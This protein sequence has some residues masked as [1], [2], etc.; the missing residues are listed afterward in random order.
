MQVSGQTKRQLKQ[1]WSAL[2]YSVY[3]VCKNVIFNNYYSNM[4]L[5]RMIVQN[6]IYSELIIHTLQQ[7]KYL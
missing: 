3:E 6:P 7:N 1:Q 4:Y 5:S 2:N